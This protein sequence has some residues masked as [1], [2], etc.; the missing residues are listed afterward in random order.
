MVSLWQE[1]DLSFEE[2][3][4]CPMDSIR[5]WKI[6]E[7]ERI[8]KFL[9]RLNMEL[10]SI[11]DRVLGRQLQSFASEIF[12]EVHQKESWGKVMLREYCVSTLF[13][14]LRISEKNQP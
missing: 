2:K 4:E 14:P 3:W 9:D 13:H 12:F 5:Y 7:N 1:L 6:V 10:D 8:I 11:Q